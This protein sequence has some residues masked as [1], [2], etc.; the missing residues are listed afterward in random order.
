MAKKNAP[1]T[2]ADLLELIGRFVSDASDLSS[3]ELEADLRAMSI[4]P[5]A[6]VRR[7][8][9]LV[10]S[11]IA[12]TRLAWKEK[13]REE[14]QAAVRQLEALEVQPSQDIKTEIAVLLA[15]LSKHG[16]VPGLQA[17][18]SKFEKAT[19]HDL[20]TLLQDLQRLKKLREITEGGDDDS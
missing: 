12:A 19:D 11:S 1:E 20:H 2:T 5:D 6:V 9:D 13:A 10:D 4:D 3:A 18:W 14:R 16:G 15:S 7:V 17:Y 8:K